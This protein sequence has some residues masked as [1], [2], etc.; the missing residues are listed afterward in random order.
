MFA[1]VELDPLFKG[2]GV[3][4]NAANPLRLKGVEV[5]RKKIAFTRWP[6]LKKIGG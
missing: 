1:P 5:W 4:I 3:T 2:A 6:C